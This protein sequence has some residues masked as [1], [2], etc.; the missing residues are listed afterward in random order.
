MTHYN[1][2]VGLVRNGE[3]SRGDR[4]NLSSRSAASIPTI[5]T[6]SRY[7]AICSRAKNCSRDPL[8]ARMRVGIGFL[9]TFDRDVRV[10]LRCRQTGVTE[11]RLDAAQIR[12]AIEHMSG[13]TVPEFVRADRDRDRSVPQ[14][15]LQDQPDRSRRHSL[16]RFVNE[17]RAGMRVRRRPIFLDR[18][19]RRHANRTNPFFSAFA[20]NAYRLRVKIDI[21][22]IERG[23]LAQTQPAAVKK[24][25]YRRVAQ[26]HPL[27][28]GAL[29]WKFQRR[30]QQFFDLLPSQ[31]ERQLLFDLWQ[32]Q[33]SQRINT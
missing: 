31:H 6:P 17:K 12:A 25:H 5:P 32:L 26:R 10:N 21:V 20:K 22:H 19:Q 28:R 11:Q 15:A 29:L 27:W 24:F 2:A 13:E 8:R 30:S 18:F 16:S 33:L 1:L 4:R 7:C 14:I 23:E 3:P 9:Q